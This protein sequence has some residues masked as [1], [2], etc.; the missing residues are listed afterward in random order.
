MAEEEGPAGDDGQEH[1]RRSDPSG[2]PR[3]GHPPV[4]SRRGPYYYTGRRRRRRHQSQ[5]SV[6]SILVSSPYILQTD[7]IHF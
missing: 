6:E 4:G 3:H 7:K 2:L 1:T 5:G